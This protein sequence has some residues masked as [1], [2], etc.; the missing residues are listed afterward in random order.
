LAVAAGIAWS[1]AQQAQAALAEFAA[2]LASGRADQARA[3]MTDELAAAPTT[4]PRLA[5]LALL[6]GAAAA[7]AGAP[8][9]E[10]TPMREWLSF[11][12]RLE[13]TLR[14]VVPG[15][16]PSLQAPF[17][18]RRSVHGRWLVASLPGV[19]AHPAALL[20]AGAGDAGATGVV[21]V[22]GQAVSIRGQAPGGIGPAGHQ[23]GF[24]VVVEES[25]AHFAPVTPVAL[26]KLLRVGPGGVETELEGLVALSPDH[27][28]YDLSVAPAAL[29][30]RLTVGASG[31]QAYAWGGRVYAVA[32]TRAFDPG[33]IRVALGTTGFA[34]LQH[35]RVT[36]SSPAQFA[37]QDRVANR[38]VTI[39]A[40]STVVFRRSAA[41]V[42]AEN[43]RG[44]V[45][46]RSGAR[47]HVVPA[48]GQR[49][50]IT[51]LT[52]GHGG[53]E[54]QPAYRGHLEVAP[55]GLGFEVGASASGAGAAAG[56][57]VVNELPLN[58]Y[59]YSVVPSEMPVAFGLESLKVQA[60][61]A[62]A[63]AVASMRQGGYASQG[64]HVEDS[65]MS[66]VYNNVPERD[67]SN[68]AVDETGLEVPV[69]AGQVV[70]ARFFS[71]SS[72]FTANAHEVWS[73]PG[74][75]FPG[76][77]VPYLRA[78]PQTSAFR[79]LPDEAT[80]GQFLARADLDAPDAP[81]AFFR[82]AVTMTR[83]ELE[84]AIRANL[85]A[86]QVAQP[87]FVLTRDAH[88]N[89]VSRPVPGTDPIGTLSDIRVIRRGEGG[90]LM[91]IEL[92]G[93]AGAYRVI[94]EYNIRTVLR[95]V[96]H[97]TGRPAVQLR[98]RDGSTRANYPLLPSAFAIFELARD[99]AGNLTQITIRGGGNG[100]GAGMSQTG[101][102]GLAL[103]GLDYRAILQRYYPGSEIVDLMAGPR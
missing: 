21:L 95:P 58:Q 17:H 40:G 43:A 48:T 4:G 35:T 68:Q 74:G 33:M 72:G 76:A 92:V 75:Q 85:A 22:R 34:G 5:S 77:A 32:G 55:A 10:T 41:E 64:A 91:E 54:F 89:F 19:L 37:I 81:A 18:M 100:H 94:K 69:F 31:L 47:L 42:V 20:L 15:G 29:L 11:L 88:G 38:R 63:Y 101:A 51:S 79:S 80:L 56:L 57:T 26:S 28:L 14:I 6:A 65:V 97:L 27:A 39:A 70:D 61:A 102:Q 59:L 16:G 36:V 78:A 24:A 96:Q 90:N 44:N 49:L 52:R 73:T 87:G 103:Q 83:G 66:Q 23:V 1:Q 13:L 7:D 25:L 98:L 46:I 99:A 82:W 30:P 8:R 2:H 9:L 50:T 84:A 53:A 62:R 12:R 60:L 86:R 3:R 45:L 71:T 93:S 67:I